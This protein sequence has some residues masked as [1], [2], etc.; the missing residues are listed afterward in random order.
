V[1]GAE[2]DEFERSAHF[3][4]AEEPDKFERDVAVFIRQHASSAP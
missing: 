4:Y 2:L 3:P 1:F